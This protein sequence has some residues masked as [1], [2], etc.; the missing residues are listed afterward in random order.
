M[1]NTDRSLGVEE[2][3]AHLRVS[4]ETIYRW[5]EVK[6]IPA[7]RASDYASML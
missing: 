3:A 7:L 5:L 6:R 2:I 1:D 4:K